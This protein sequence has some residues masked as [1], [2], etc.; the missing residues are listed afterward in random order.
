MSSKSSLDILDTIYLYLSSKSFLGILDTKYLYL[1]SKSSLD[2]LDTRYLYL[3]SKSS[4]DILDT[5]DLCC[6]RRASGLLKSISRIP[7]DVSFVGI[8]SSSRSIL[9]LKIK[10]IP[11][12]QTL[13]A[14][15]QKIRWV[16]I[17][18]NKWILKYS[19][20]HPYSKTMKRIISNYRQHMDLQHRIISSELTNT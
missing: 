16:K 13:S 15:L 7:P 4:L 19:Q 12:E 11:T 17:D 10:E 6:R 3:S 2:I 14:K 9:V 1:S 20:S 18:L 8:R 5:M